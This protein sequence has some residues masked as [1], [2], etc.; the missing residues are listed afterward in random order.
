MSNDNDHVGFIRRTL[1]D[2][3]ISVDDIQERAFPGENWIIVYVPAE[4]LLASQSLAGT[5]ERGLNTTG[6][7]DEV[8]FTVVF[9]ARAEE[10][11]KDTTD[12]KGG[13]LSDPK[14]DQLIQLL[15]ARSRTSDALPSLRYIEDP[16]A[17]LA[18]VGASRHQ[19]IYGRRGV[20]K[21]ALFSRRSAL[22][23]GKEMLPYG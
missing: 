22:L 10:Q 9:R 8:P 13:R 2:A 11:E 21:T 4:L 14:F 7:R 6:I 5:I 15:E 23:R 16:R 12:G 3:N 19:L 1:D 17:N 20:G 18:A